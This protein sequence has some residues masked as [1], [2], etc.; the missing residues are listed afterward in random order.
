MPCNKSK[1][2]FQQQK[3]F[4]LGYTAG[5]MNSWIVIPS[6][7]FSGEGI[8]YPEKLILLVLVELTALNTYNQAMSMFRYYFLSTRC[9]RPNFQLGVGQIILKVQHSGSNTTK[10]ASMLYLL[11]P[12]SGALRISAYRDFLP[13]PNPIHP[14]YSF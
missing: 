10:L 6:P 2:I 1:P 9:L 5:G 8:S 14:T 13:I 11:A 4:L 7:Q 3:S 12:R